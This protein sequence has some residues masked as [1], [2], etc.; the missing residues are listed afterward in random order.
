MSDAVTETPATP[1][2]WTLAVVRVGIGRVAVVD[3][4][5]DGVVNGVGG[6]RARAGQGAGQ[7]GAAREPAAKPKPRDWTWG[8]G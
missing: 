2:A 4:R 1:L 5:G 6:V 7:S 8:I 3:I